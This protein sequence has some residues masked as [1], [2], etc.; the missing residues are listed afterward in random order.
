[1]FESLQFFDLHIVAPGM[2]AATTRRWF[3]ISPQ[4]APHVGDELSQCVRDG[5]SMTRIIGTMDCVEQT[6]YK[7]GRDAATD[8]TTS[9]PGNHN[10]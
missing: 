7:I 3:R 1:M 9:D 4:S 10:A 8:P 2:A 5:A 6:S